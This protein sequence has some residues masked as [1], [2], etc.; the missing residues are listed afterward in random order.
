MKKIIMYFKRIFGMNY[1]AMFKTINKVHKRSGKSKIKIF[2]DM[3]K[4]SIKYSAGYTDY[5]LFCFEDLND[6]QRST[7]ITRGI[8]N[9]I[10]QLNDREYYKYFRDKVLF[11][12]TFKEYLGR[13][14]IDLTKSSL[15]DFKKFLEVNPI[16][17]VKPIDESGGV[18]IEKIKIEKETDIEKLYNNLIDTK[19][20]LVEE[21]V[22][23]HD[24][25]AKLCASSVNTLRI[26]TIT[27]NNKTHIMVRVIRMGNGINAVDNFHAGGMYTVFDENGVITK[28]AIDREGN[29]YEEHPFTKTKIEGFKIP[30]YKESIELV[31]QVCKKMGRED[32]QIM[33]GP[34]YNKLN[35]DD[36][37]KTSNHTINVIGKFDEETYI[38][39]LGGHTVVNESKNGCDM[40][41]IKR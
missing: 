11:N 26:V 25:M 13:N 7:Y 27:K 5:F 21:C 17:I 40:Y 23:Q 10:R 6:L 36:L 1:K 8:N 12:D 14:Y 33:F 29:I 31:K 16:I 41:E 15:D 19:R 20:T 37:T 18:G 38:D 3:I 4:C 24:E 34:N 2:F 28:P 30:Y 35:F 22:V 39:A 32:A 9:N